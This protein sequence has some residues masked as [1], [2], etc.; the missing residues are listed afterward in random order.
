MLHKSFTAPHSEQIFLYPFMFYFSCHLDLLQS[1]MRGSLGE[2]Y[3]S[4]SFIIRTREIS[5][6]PPHGQW[7]N[8]CS[9]FSSLLVEYICTSA[10]ILRDLPKTWDSAVLPKTSGRPKITTYQTCG[11][12]MRAGL[13]GISVPLL[14]SHLFPLSPAA[15]Q[16]L[17]HC[18]IHPMY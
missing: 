6:N 11:C 16:S 5:P 2:F 14:L 4:L 8:C 9:I 13:Q 18:F 15:M 10:Q 7:S 1:T 3:S 12:L 17:N